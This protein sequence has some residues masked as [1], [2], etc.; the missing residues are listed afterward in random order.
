M[1][2]L[3]SQAVGELER[4]GRELGLPTRP[5]LGFYGAGSRRGSEGRTLP[6]PQRLPGG[7][8]GVTGSLAHPAFSALKQA[9]QNLASRSPLGRT[10][11]VGFWRRAAHVA[12]VGGQRPDSRPLQPPQRG[13]S[14]PLKAGSAL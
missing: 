1:L 8:D 2:D 10:A 13:E 6:G 3:A 4:E 7:Q 9:V 14:R 12:G 11:K 5:M